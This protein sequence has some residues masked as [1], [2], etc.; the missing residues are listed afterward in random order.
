MTEPKIA[1][2]GGGLSAAFAWRACQDVGITPDVYADRIFVPPGGFIFVHWLPDS[3]SRREL[4]ETIY[5]S[6]VGNER[7]YSSKMWYRSDVKTSF[8]EKERT[9]K[10]VNPLKAAK[11]LWGDSKFLAKHLKLGILPE[12]ALP[13]LAEEYDAVI[14]TFPL[15]TAK[16][17]RLTPIWVVPDKELPLR[18]EVIYIG[19]QSQFYSRSARMFGFRSYEFPPIFQ[20]NERSYLAELWG[21]VTGVEGEKGAKLWYA[22]EIPPPETEGRIRIALDR[23]GKFLYCGRWATGWRKTLSHESYQRTFDF[24]RDLGLLQKE[25]SDGPVLLSEDA[26]RGASSETVGEAA[27]LQSGT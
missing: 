2:L 20:E 12:S 7:V 19:D 9:V 5:I 23:D 13:R 3:V 25:V 22:P 1:I 21:N 6:F 14:Q 15:E 11:I 8:P 17:D 10:G 24:L 16:P 26:G 27:A 18:N 4:F